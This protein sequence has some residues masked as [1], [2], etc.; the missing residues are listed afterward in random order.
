MTKQNFH[1]HTTFCDGKSTAEEMV[2]SAIEKG[3]TALG[4]SS[5]SYEQCYGNIRMP[6]E[7]MPL[8]KDEIYRLKEKYKDRIKIY[9]GIEL[10]SCSDIDVSDF[11][12]VIASVHIIKKN[13][14]YYRIGDSEELFIENVKKG[15]NGDYYAFAKDY[16]EEVSLLEG[17]I[18]GHIDFITI[19][20]EGDRLFSTKAKKYLSYAEEAVKKIVKKNMLFEINTGAISRGRRSTPYPSAEILKIIKKYGGKITINSDC[21]HKDDIDSGYEMAFKL[22]KE[23]GFDKVHYLFEN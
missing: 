14:K 3:F 2:L 16:F 17:D 8:Y 1:T 15:W 9:H 13:N 5:H 12:F 10:D 23:C 19:F 22:A 20:N 7:D 18:V 11:E 4:F 6:I 21:H